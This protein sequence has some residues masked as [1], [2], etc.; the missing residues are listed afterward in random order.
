[1]SAIKL[2]LKLANLLGWFCP[3][4]GQFC[5]WCVA[6]LSPE[7]IQEAKLIIARANAAKRVFH[8]E[9]GPAI[10]ATAAEVTAPAATGQN[11]HFCSV[12]LASLCGEFL[13][14]SGA[15]VA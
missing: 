2:R 15:E 11:I 8:W 3:S 1:M 4:V 13:H 10:S 7:G 9:R 14:K 12:F 6:R 5:V